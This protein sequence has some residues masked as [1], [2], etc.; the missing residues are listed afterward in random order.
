MDGLLDICQSAMGCRCALCSWAGSAICL[1][2]LLQ[3]TLHS[4]CRGHAGMIIAARALF[5]ADKTS[6]TLPPGLA[7]SYFIVL[8]A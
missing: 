3:N 5:E 6:P 7:R 2:P 4:S 1:L 8:V